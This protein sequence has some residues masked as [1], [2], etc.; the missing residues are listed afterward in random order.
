[1][2]FKKMYKDTNAAWFDI[3]EKEALADLSKV[4]MSP[5]SV[6]DTMTENPGMTINLPFSVLVFKGDGMYV[7]DRDILDRIYDTLFENVGMSEHHIKFLDETVT[8]QEVDNVIKFK[9]N[10]VGYVL[11]LERILDEY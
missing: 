10:G 8:D 1:M 5:Y 9:V 3:S 2:G 4:F 6:F 7:G 11:K